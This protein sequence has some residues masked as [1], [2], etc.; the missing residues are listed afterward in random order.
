VRRGAN[1]QAQAEAVEAIKKVSAEYDYAHGK[2]CVFLFSIKRSLINRMMFPR[3]D[4][5]DRIWGHVARSI[6][7]GPLK[8]AGVNTAKVAPTPVGEE[9]VGLRG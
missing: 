4:D 6:A 5:V 2:W 8:D 9:E 1:L 7:H 3:H